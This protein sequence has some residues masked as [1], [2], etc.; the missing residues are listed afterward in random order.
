VK[1]FWDQDLS[2]CLALDSTL[3]VKFVNNKAAFQ[4]QIKVAIL[5]DKTLKLMFSFF[6][7]AF[8][9]VCDDARDPDKN[10]CCGKYNTCPLNCRSYTVTNTRGQHECQCGDCTSDF[11][12]PVLKKL[13]PNISDIRDR[14]CKIGQREW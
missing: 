7:L 13:V 14:N 6:C 2:S 4:Q 9:Y 12:F 3:S 1:R 5:F 8:D 11:Q 10:G